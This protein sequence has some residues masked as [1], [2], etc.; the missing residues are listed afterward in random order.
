L[1]VSLRIVRGCGALLRWA[2]GGAC[3]YTSIGGFGILLL[4][5]G[6][7]G[8]GLAGVYDEASR[9][10][11]NSGYGF[12]CKVPAGWVLR[13]EQMNAAAAGLTKSP[14]GAAPPAKGADGA[15]GSRV[16][17]AALERPPEVTGAGFAAVI[18]VA[19]EKQ[20]D[21]P[22]VKA[23]EDYFEP[24]TQVFTAKRLKAVNDPYPFQPVAIPAGLRVMR[25]DFVLEEKDRDTIYQSSLVMLSHGAIVS[26][27]FAAASEEDVDGLIEGLS[28][29]RGGAG[30]KARFPQRLKPNNLK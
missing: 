8:Q 3:P 28:F 11:R 20:S 29:G 13:T 17:L 2:G 5:A 22:G 25:E 30:A 16:L 27:T 21:Y 7:F 4:A 6:L 19:A 23:A 24:M 12:S 26:F 18:V 9:V 14:P 1:G 10:Y 15:S